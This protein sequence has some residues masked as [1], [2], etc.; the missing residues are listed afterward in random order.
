MVHVELVLW[1]TL[2]SLILVVGLRCELSLAYWNSVDVKWTGIILCAGVVHVWLL[3][4]V[5][6]LCVLLCNGL[7]G[8][9][10][11][12]GKWSRLSMQVDESDRRRSLPLLKSTGRS[13]WVNL[14]SLATRY[15]S[16]GW[17]WMWG[18]Q[19]AARFDILNWYSSNLTLQHLVDL[20]RSLILH[21]LLVYQWIRKSL[22]ETLERGLLLGIHFHKLLL[23]TLVDEKLSCLVVLC[24]KR[25]VHIWLRW[26]NPSFF[27]HWLWICFLIGQHLWR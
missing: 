25:D 9:K 2:Y 13:M 15:L 11:L 4:G 1:K 22:N 3:A 5:G 14:G 12:L 18:R 23:C 17:V 26:I 7:I 21:F 16:W 27:I 24:L 8:W 6:L 19:V 20:P 10:N